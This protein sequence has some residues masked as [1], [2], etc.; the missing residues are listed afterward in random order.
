MRGLAEAGAG[1]LELEVFGGDCVRDIERRLWLIDLNDWP[2]YAP[3]R[4][5]AAEAIAS[6]LIGQRGPT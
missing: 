2:S 1:A 6:Y 3:C 5:G 4:F